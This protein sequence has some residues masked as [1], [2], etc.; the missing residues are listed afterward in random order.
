MTG[1]ETGGIAG[2]FAWPVLFSDAY[3]ETLHRAHF[4]RHQSPL[5]LWLLVLISGLHTG[6]FSS[7]RLR[8]RFSDGLIVSYAQEVRCGEW[9]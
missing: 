1:I 8:D 7:N 9:A 5:H 2:D 6:V 3:V 4:Q